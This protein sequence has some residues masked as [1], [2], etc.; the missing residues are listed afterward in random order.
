MSGEWA[1]QCYLNRKLRTS[2]R[3]IFLFWEIPKEN[4]FLKQGLFCG[5]GYDEEFDQVKAK[6][7][8]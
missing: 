7:I 6:L 4:I 3:V 5:D 1:C 2:P 8:S